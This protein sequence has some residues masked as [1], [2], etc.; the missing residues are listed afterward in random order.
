MY[1]YYIMSG[2]HWA[3]NGK[4]FND[5]FGSAKY[6]RNYLQKQLFTHSKLFVFHV[7]WKFGIMRVRVVRVMWEM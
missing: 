5:K 3:I 1:N 7:Q 4:N 6:L 2:F